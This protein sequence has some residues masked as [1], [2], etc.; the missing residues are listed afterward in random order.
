M[1]TAQA[2][3]RMEKQEG[4][5]PRGTKGV[6]LLWKR[7]GNCEKEEYKN[8]GE[9]VF[10]LCDDEGVLKSSQDFTVDDC[11]V[12]LNNHTQRIIKDELIF[13]L[14]ELR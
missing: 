6:E 7:V 3:G 11:W 13:A 5:P 4:R 10:T 9:Q 12:K 8:D 1:N 2:H 14:F